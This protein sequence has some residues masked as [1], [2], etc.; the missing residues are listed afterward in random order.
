M[1]TV[2]NLKLL[3][4]LSDESKNELLGLIIEKITTAIQE[5]LQLDCLTKRLETIALDLCVL[6]YHKVVTYGKD[7][8]VAGDISVTA[9]DIAA[10]HKTIF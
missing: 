9:S 6:Q 7:S 10:V 4:C 2:E 1:L 8:T 3:L 5:E